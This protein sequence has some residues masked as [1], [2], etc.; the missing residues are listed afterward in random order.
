MAVYRLLNRGVLAK[1]GHPIRQ[2][3]ESIVFYGAAP[4]GRELAVKIHSSQVFGNR[5]RRQFIFG[6]WRF[7]HAKRHITLRTETIWAEKE[8]RNLHRLAKAGIH[9]PR[10]V[11]FEENVVVMSFI[12]QNG[13]AAPQLNELD[14]TDYSNLAEKTF[15]VLDRLVSRASLIHGDLSPYNILVTNNIPYIIDISQALLVTHSR[16]K[17]LLQGDIQNLLTFFERKGVDLG[18]IERVAN[19]ILREVNQQEQNSPP[20][21][22]HNDDF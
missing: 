18:P 2:G 21:R 19:D 11:A 12:G 6:D 22:I 10:P 20:K 8:H 13:I 17:E 7:R 3:K 4:D 14:V 16:A 9:A 15:R 5:E 1:L